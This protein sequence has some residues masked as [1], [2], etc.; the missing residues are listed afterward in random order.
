M[1]YCQNECLVVFQDQKALP[2]TPDEHKIREYLSLPRN[3]CELLEYFQIIVGK[4]Q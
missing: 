1:Y 2:N 4:R 3:L